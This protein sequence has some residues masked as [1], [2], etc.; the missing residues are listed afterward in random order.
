MSLNKLDGILIRIPD[1]FDGAVE[2]GKL[3]GEPL[4][5]RWH[6]FGG[7]EW[8]QQVVRSGFLQGRNYIPLVMFAADSGD[9]L[10]AGA[11]PFAGRG[12]EHA[13]IAVLGDLINDLHGGRK[14]RNREVRPDAKARLK[15]QVWSLRISSVRD[16]YPRAKYPLGDG[17]R[18]KSRLTACPRIILNRQI[19]LRLPFS[20]AFSTG[21]RCVRNCSGRTSPRPPARA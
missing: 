9:H 21:R 10:S 20:A 2:Q 1:R 16:H 8:F 14:T 5:Y 17:R 7:F 4:L 15:T 11:G 6:L 19:P 18:Q 13:S 3:C 12:L